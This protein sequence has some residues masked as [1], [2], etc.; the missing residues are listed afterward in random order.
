MTPHEAMQRIDDLL[1]HVWMVRTFLKHSDEVQED[2]E[3]ND[4]Y[5]ALYDSMHALGESAKQNDAEHYLRQAQK[6][7]AKLRAATERFSELQPEISTHTNFQMAARS[8]RTAVEGVGA[9]LADLALP[10]AGRE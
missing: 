10:G 5:R 9:I 6:K 3:L 4:I 1:S 7:F 2:E 8:L